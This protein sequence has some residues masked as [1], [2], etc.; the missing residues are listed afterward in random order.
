MTDKLKVL[1]LFSGIGG[2]SLG[3]E[4]TGG[5]E[6]VAFCEIDPHNRSI[7]AQH[8]PT[9]PIFND[10]T[11]LT[12]EQI[13]HADFICGGFPC[14][15]A[16]IA[17]IGGA[18]AAGARTGLFRE[19]VR[20][21]WQL[22]CRA[23]LMENVP[24]LLNRGF[25]DILGALAEIGFDAEWECISARDMGACHERERLWIMAY[26]QCTGREGFEPLHGILGRAKAS[27]AK[28]GN[29]PLGGW[30]EMVARQRGIRIGD[31]VSVGM[32]RRR[33]FGLGNAVIPDIPELIG[34]TILASIDRAAA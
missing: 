32:E 27:L 2:F 8:W 17:N 21:A 12:A 9:V 33:L 19:I 26:P 7:L 4:R 34:R 10:V 31:G 28:H 15:D 20:L 3:L 25:G 5:F 11:Q 1:D 18:G 29:A 22:E 14:Q 23:I 6:T 13:G 24:N 30:S 16:S